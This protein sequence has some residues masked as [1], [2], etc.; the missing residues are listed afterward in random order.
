MTLSC[1]SEVLSRSPE[2][3]G[4]PLSSSTK[5]R[6]SY[7]HTTLALVRNHNHPDGQI[8]LDAPVEFDVLSQDCHFSLAA[9]CLVFEATSGIV[10]RARRNGLDD[11]P[12]QDRA[13]GG[14]LAIGTPRFPCLADLPA[15]T[16][17]GNSAASAG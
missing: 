2:Y 9:L 15:D 11:D 13:D 6:T 4:P 3:R 8:D 17:N 5:A 12:M 7:S 14:T 1:V 10:G 16:A